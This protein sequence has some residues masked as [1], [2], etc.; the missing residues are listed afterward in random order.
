MPW[1]SCPAGSQAS[2]SRPRVRTPSAS[3]EG[4]HRPLFRDSEKGIPFCVA[5]QKEDGVPSPEGVLGSRPG[6]QARVLDGTNNYAIHVPQNAL[7]NMHIFYGEFNS[8]ELRYTEPKF[9]APLGKVAHSF[10]KNTRSLHY[11]APGPAV[12]DFFEP[13]GCEPLGFG[14]HFGYTNVYHG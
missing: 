10:T 2:D 12:R 9:L 6:L 14:V 11:H 3:A 8:G 13:R 1:D 5:R 4:K 7:K